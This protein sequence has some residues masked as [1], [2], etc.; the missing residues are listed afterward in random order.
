MVDHQGTTD[1]AQAFE[2]LRAEVSVLR[3]AV[4]ALPGA[5][6]QNRPP[7]YSPD[8]GEIAKQVTSFT[9]Q[10]DAFQNHP[11]L[12]MTP[13]QHREAVARAGS[14]LVRDAV[15]RLDQ[16]ANGISY[17]G[18]QLADLIGTARRQE[19]QRNWLIW[20]GLGAFVV[21]LVLAPP[22]FAA[23]PFGLNDRIGAFIVGGGDRWHAGIELMQA[24]SP[25][26]W[27]NLAQASAW[28][29]PCRDKAAATNTSQRCVIEVP[30]P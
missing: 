8:L 11:A 25:E 12:R 27:N 13:D 6:E 14:N 22:L 23:L 5:W 3:R 7:D 28:V 2:D 29:Q 15:Q 17:E 16:A 19:E 21:G 26:G 9:D 4:E 20:T 10:L 30:G 24:Q 18:R 1:P